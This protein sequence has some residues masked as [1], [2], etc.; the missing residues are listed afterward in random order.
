MYGKDDFTPEARGSKMLVDFKNSALRCGGIARQVDGDVPERYIAELCQS[1][2]Y[3][4]LELE[5]MISRNK[6]K[7]PQWH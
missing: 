2:H 7:V 3:L 5:A 6:W 1:A 4:K